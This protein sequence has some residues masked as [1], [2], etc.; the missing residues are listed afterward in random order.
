MESKSETNQDYSPF[1]SEE[2]RQNLAQYKHTLDRPL[3]DEQLQFLDENG[4]VV[5][6]N[7]ISKNLCE[8]IVREAT[9]RAPDV[10]GVDMKR[11]ETWKKLVK[12]GCVNIWNLPSLYIL[13][14]HPELYSVFA[15]LLKTHRLA[16]SIDRIGLKSPS[17]NPEEA[18]KTNA[19][20]PLHNDL[21]MWHSDPSF[22]YFQGGLCLKDCPEGGG[23]FFCIPK[24]HKRENFE[25]YMKKVES[26]QFGNPR[27]KIPSAEHMFVQFE[28]IEYAKQHKIEV[29]LNQGDFIIWNGYLPHNGGVNSLTNHWRWHA[30]VRFLPLDSMASKQEQIWY[31][32]YQKVTNECRKT[33]KMPTHYSTGNTVKTKSRDA[34][35]PFHKVVE[36]TPLGERIFGET[37][38]E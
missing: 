22:P 11:E 36:L 2:Q 9:K 21:N 32:E 12:H 29:P 23:G 38:Y 14:Q 31:R 25:A 26:G 20:L 19:D 6:P 37:P 8:Q 28:D 10:L 15:Q 7:L 3:T 24:F 30:F 18:K 16:V 17:K 33:G 27:F 4:Y 5:I 13:R 34:E 35:V 1:L